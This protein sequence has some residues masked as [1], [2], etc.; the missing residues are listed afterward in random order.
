MDEL[1][2][3]DIMRSVRTLGPW[4]D[5]GKA[6]ELMRASS[7]PALPV[8]AQG[9]VVGIVSEEDLAGCL[10]DGGDAIRPV[11]SA[12]SVLVQEI[13]REPCEVLKD[14]LSP[15]EAA[16]VFTRTQCSMLPVVDRYGFYIGL[17]GRLDLLS[18]QC[19][20]LHPAVIGGM[21][22]P[23]GVY[24]T[25]G[26]FGMGAGNLGLF[27]T[28]ASLMLLNCIALLM[29]QGLQWLLW[30]G[31]SAASG[32]PVAGM[33]GPGAAL[34][35][36]TLDVLPIL[37]FLLLI[38]LSPLAGYH[39]AEHQ[40][41]HAIENGEPLIPEVVSR[42][43]RVHPRCG[44]N[45]MA[46][47]MVMMLVVTLME[48]TKIPIQMSV[49]V[50]ALVAMATWRTVG[51]LLQYYITTRPPSLKQLESG[52][53]AGKALLERY[54]CQP[55]RPVNLKG[56]LWYS[57]ILQVGLG[58]LITYVAVLLAFGPFVDPFFGPGF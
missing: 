31:F 10:G 8:V 46:G 39:A 49:L 38:R 36:L 12:R 4:D 5:I 28:G 6:S 51:E 58:F 44:T 47:M 56:R 13:M 50:A 54:Q 34:I 21:A 42:M 53:A 14:A 24:L 16:A 26:T 1:T 20:T 18:Y 52:I 29:A 48:P 37:L 22:T 43:P 57:G 41:V 27:L 55:G 17:L 35:S 25:T 19:R 45:F 33:P 9:R 11:G 32:G 2:V 7:S 40:V 3:R 15:Q 23:L 30:H